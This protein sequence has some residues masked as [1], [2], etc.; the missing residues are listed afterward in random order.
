MTHRT[1]AQ[2]PTLTS[3]VGSMSNA[4]DIDQA[5]REA[6]DSVACLA[7]VV[8]ARV[9]ILCPDGSTETTAESDPCPVPAA[10]RRRRTQRLRGDN[11]ER[12]DIALLDRGGDVVGTLSIYNRIGAG[13]DHQT[14]ALVAELAQQL[15]LAI[16]HHRLTARLQRAHR[17]LA[18]QRDKLSMAEQTWRIAFQ[19]APIGMSMLA[20][21][22][23]PGRLLQVNQ[24]LCQLSGYS[25]TQLTS[26]SVAQLTHPEDRPPITAVLHRAAAGRRT[27]STLHVRFL[28]RGGRILPVRLTTSPVFTEDRGPLYAIGHIEELSGQVR[29]DTGPLIDNPLMEP[30]SRSAL[31]QTVGHTMQRAHR[32]ATTAAVMLCDLR[33][34]HSRA[35]QLSPG[36]AAEYNADLARR[37]RRAL[38]PED[39]LSRLDE[40]TLAIVLEELTAADADAIARRVRTALGDAT[41]DTGAQCTI[42]VG[43]GIGM[44]KSDSGDADAVLSAAS[45]ALRLSR[46]TGYGT[47]V[48]YP[49]SPPPGR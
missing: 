46:A 7:G 41:H 5:A 31:T 16:E 11:S 12:C 38:R 49:C 20:L 37:L 21:D 4:D 27:P 9:R 40:T 48:T 18:A 14:A 36:D 44:I 8:G 19:E 23:H 17:Q 1:Q 35:A 15:G 32:T 13:L 34:V 22:R 24:A 25:V 43:I 28:H 6:V 10:R 47:R 29:P 26:R 33:G 2:P 42:D 30:P 39:V 3:L 45:G